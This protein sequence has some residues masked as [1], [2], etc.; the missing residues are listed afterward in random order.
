MVSGHKPYKKTKHNTKQKEKTM[1]QINKVKRVE[2]TLTEK[3]LR[4]ISIALY[5]KKKREEEQYSCAF[6]S[7]LNILE[8]ID[9]AYD[10][11]VS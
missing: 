10:F 9:E 6:D 7:T 8:V 1:A 5:E 11:T 4:T 3:E 2:L